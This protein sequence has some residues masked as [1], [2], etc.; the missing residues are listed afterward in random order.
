MRH[1]RANSGFVLLM[2]LVV[3]LIAGTVLT[4]SARYS[5]TRA[6]EAGAAERELQVRWGSRSCRDFFLDS[7]E[8]MLKAIAADEST[9]AVSVCRSITLKNLK[10]HVVLSDEQAKANVNLLASLQS[11]ETLS[12]RLRGLQ[13]EQ[14]E[15][16]EV[17]LRPGKPPERGP[18]M[19]ANRISR[20]PISGRPISAGMGKVTFVEFPMLYVSMDQVFV[21]SHP[22]ELIAP[23]SAK[24]VINQVT[25]WSDGRLNFKRAEVPVLREVS[26]GLLDETQ[27]SQLAAF[28]KDHADCTLGEALRSLELTKTQLDALKG[29]LTDAS[30]CH[31]VWVIA[32]GE[33]RKWYRFYVA[34]SGGAKADS[35]SRWAFEW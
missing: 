28:S 33:T 25:C 9:I 32:E 14:S 4:A 22:S 7:A 20:S 19:N 12:A 31:S 8:P 29:V 11:N 16:L 13:S 30:Q 18:N 23:G 1:R 6:L 3:L 17:L 24:P 10:F 26:G 15:P 34:R 21:F 5:Y 2:V 27:I 35:M